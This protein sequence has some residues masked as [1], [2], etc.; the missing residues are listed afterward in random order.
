[1]MFNAAFPI[2]AEKVKPQRIGFRIHGVQKLLTEN[3]PLCRRNLTFK[4]GELHTL[5]EIGAGF[6][7]ATEPPPSLNRF[8]RDVI[9]NQNQHIL[10][11][12]K[13]WIIFQISAEMTGKSLIEK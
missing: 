2:G 4:N 6:G 3:R 12:N 1:M 7:N 13:G 5:P 11:P 10:A 8:C 9:R